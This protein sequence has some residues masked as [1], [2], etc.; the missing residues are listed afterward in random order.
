LLNG[1]A[2]PIQPN[3]SYITRT[4]RA[5]GGQGPTL[6][7]MRMVVLTTAPG[8]ALPRQARRPL[9][10]QDEPKSNHRVVDVATAGACIELSRDMAPGIAPA[11][12]RPANDLATRGYRQVWSTPLLSVG[13]SHY[14]NQQAQHDHA[15]QS[16]GLEY[17]GKVHGILVRRIRAPA[18]QKR[19]SRNNLA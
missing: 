16:D 5:D 10:L 4:A 12:F 18:F 11:G 14:S 3:A 13:H 17:F 6:S 1:T 15:D 19:S 9:E 7:F 8:S 2:G